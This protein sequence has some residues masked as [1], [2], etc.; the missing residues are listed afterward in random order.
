MHKTC[1]EPRLQWSQAKKIWHNAG[2]R[3][4]FYMLTAPLRW[5]RQLFRR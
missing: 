4:V 5:V 3:A 1:L 2:I